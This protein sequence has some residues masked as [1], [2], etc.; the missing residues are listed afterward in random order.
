MISYKN[1]NRVKKHSSLKGIFLCYLIIQFIFTLSYSFIQAPILSFSSWPIKLIQS[2]ERKIE[3]HHQK[4]KRK[5]KKEITI[6][7]QPEKLI[8]TSLINLKIKS[9]SIDDP[10][11]KIC[12]YWGA[13]EFEDNFSINKAENEKDFISKNLIYVDCTGS[14]HLINTENS[15]ITEFKNSIL[16]IDLHNNEMR[17]YAKKL[18]IKKEFFPVHTNDFKQIDKNK[19]LFSFTYWDTS[20]N[21]ARLALKSINLDKSNKWKNIFTSS[22]VY[23]RNRDDRIYD[24]HFTGGAIQKFDASSILF[25]TGDFGFDGSN[26]NEDYPQDHNSPFGKILKINLNNNNISIYSLGHRNPEG[27]I[28]TSKGDI[29]STEHGPAG[30]DELNKIIHGKNY[31]WPYVTYG[32]DY[33]DN[34][35]PLQSNTNQGK[36]DG[37]EK[38]LFSWLP[39]IGIGNLVEIKKFHKVWDGDILIASLRAQSIFRV[40][41]ENDKRVVYTEQINL[42]DGIRDILTK[43]GFIILLTSSSKIMFINAVNKKL[44]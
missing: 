6:S 3:K 7:R 14:F 37:F 36:H 13:I 43:D 16:N 21:C 12:S 34:F 5:L 24:G 35:W 41:I 33:D 18:G 31:G 9:Y 20:E 15:T 19:Y 38:P 22:C 44:H 26:T 10:T 17:L 30:G 39:D 11:Q 29:Y 25:T 40:R 32:I 28:R 42:Q 8:E 2:I 4:N 23:L 1:F 27:I